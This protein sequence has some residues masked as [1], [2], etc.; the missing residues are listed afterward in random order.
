MK[1]RVYISGAIMFSPDKG[2]AA[3]LEAEDALLSLGFEAI[4]P[5]NVAACPDRSCIRLPDEEARGMV[6]SWACFLKYDLAAMLACDSILMLSGWERS[7]GARL[8][9]SVAAACGMTIMH[10]VD[11]DVTSFEDGQSFVH[12]GG[13]C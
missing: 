4:N 13:N 3:F 12:I 2:R 6:H 1:D 10:Y 11:G 8:E 7:H 9:M 5:K